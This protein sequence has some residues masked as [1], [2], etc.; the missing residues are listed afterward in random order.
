[1]RGYDFPP[2]I[3]SSYGMREGAILSLARRPL[4]RAI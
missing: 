1:M 3:V 4:L 2:F